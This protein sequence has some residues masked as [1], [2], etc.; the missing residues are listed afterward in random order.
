MT[1]FNGIPKL[2]DVE[3]ELWIAARINAIAEASEF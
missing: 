1:L 2:S 3:A